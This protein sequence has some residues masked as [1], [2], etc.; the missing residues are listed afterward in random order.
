MGIRFLTTILLSHIFGISSYALFDRYYERLTR[1]N[2]QTS[3]NPLNQAQMLEDDP[4]EFTD[5]SPG[6]SIGFMVAPLAKSTGIFAQDNDTRIVLRVY[7]RQRR[8]CD[9]VLS[10]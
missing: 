9:N 6:T 4:S 7:I 2:P 10:W 8:K 5:D 3:F 1:D